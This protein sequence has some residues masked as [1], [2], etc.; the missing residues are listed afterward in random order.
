[1]PTRRRG[2]LDSALVPPP[3]P[4]PH[5]ITQVL[6]AAGDTSSNGDV[7]KHVPGHDRWEKV[8]QLKLGGQ[9]LKF[10]G[11]KMA[12]VGER[13]W[14]VSGGNRQTDGTNKYR[15]EVFNLSVIA[16]FW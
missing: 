11:S 14:L 2:F 7:Y 10:Y 1:M 4:C 16:P 6:F 12:V 5:S 3:F 8:S 13:I 9:P 15:K